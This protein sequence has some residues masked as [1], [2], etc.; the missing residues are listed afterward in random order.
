MVPDSLEKIIVDV[1]I[2]GRTF[3]Q[4]LSPVA[5]QMVEFV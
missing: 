1:S 5:N 3:S 4:V 2:A